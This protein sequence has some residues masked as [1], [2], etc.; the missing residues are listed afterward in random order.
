L[1]H[2]AEAGFPGRSASPASPSPSSSTSTSGS[3]AASNSLAEEL[4]ASDVALQFLTGEL[5]GSHDPSG[6]VFT[7]LAAMSGAAS[8]VSAPVPCPG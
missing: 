1:G 8:M 3:A 5:K 7:V 6:I 4:K 2:E